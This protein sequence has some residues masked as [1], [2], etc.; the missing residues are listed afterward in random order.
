MPQLANRRHEI[1]AI[2]L[3]AGTPLLSV[4]RGTG[5]RETYSAPFRL[6]SVA[7]ARFLG[8]GQERLHLVKL[9]A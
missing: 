1:F 8:D 7:K 6:V 4:Y 5:Y 2:E 3:A 9:L